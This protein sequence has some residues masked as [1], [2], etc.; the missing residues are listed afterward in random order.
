MALRLLRSAG[1]ASVG[2]TMRS[3]RPM[4]SAIVLCSAALVGYLTLTPSVSSSGTPLA[5]AA[6]ADSTV[7][8]RRVRAGSGASLDIATPSA[9]GALAS[10]ADW[11]TGDLTVNDLR[12]GSVRRLHVQTD[13]TPDFAAYVESSRISPDGRRIAFA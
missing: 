12:D 2:V 9:D 4:V 8:T 3:P 11:D 5:R 1:Q 13:S 7:V 6:A 10:S